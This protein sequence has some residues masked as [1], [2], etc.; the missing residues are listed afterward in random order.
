M[1]LT[2]YQE[3]FVADMERSCEKLRSTGKG[4]DLSFPPRCV[5][6]LTSIIRGKR[7]NPIPGGMKMDSY[8]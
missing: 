1:D 4:H 2:E 6:K 7:M 8:V 3:E 5:E